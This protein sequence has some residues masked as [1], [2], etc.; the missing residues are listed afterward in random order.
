MVAHK[1]A[2]AY[3]AQV[4]RVWVRWPYRRF[5]AVGCWP[6]I[7]IEEPEDLGGEALEA[8]HRSMRR[9]AWMLTVVVVLLLVAV[10]LMAVSLA[11]R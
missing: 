9:N 6:S 11:S 7:G 10:G 3:E 5:M 8:W 2:T 4:G 1:G